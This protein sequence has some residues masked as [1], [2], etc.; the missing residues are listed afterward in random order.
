MKRMDKELGLR[1]K[2]K[3]LRK[4]ISLYEVLGFFL[5]EPTP[6]PS[7]VVNAI[8]QGFDDR[9]NG[10]RNLDE[11]FG[12]T[13]RPGKQLDKSARKLRYAPGVYWEVVRRSEAGEAIDIGMFEEIAA[14]MQPNF[15]KEWPSVKPPSGRTLKTWYL[16]ELKKREPELAKK[17]NKS[18]SKTD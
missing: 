5:H 2:L 17:R 12:L 8:E 16:E 7:W 11:V 14:E 10:K 18:S 15:L 3:Y 6:L 13:P 1:L 9:L 4:E